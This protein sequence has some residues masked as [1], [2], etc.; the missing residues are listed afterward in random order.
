MELCACF[1]DVGLQSPD[2][3]LLGVLEAFEFEMVLDDMVREGAWSHC[4]LILKSSGRLHCLPQSVDRQLMY[5]CDRPS[6][7]ASYLSAVQLLTFLLSCLTD[8]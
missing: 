4:D 1:V 3:R 8:N 5:H 2:G 7:L 6:P